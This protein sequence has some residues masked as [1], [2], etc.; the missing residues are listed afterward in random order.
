MRRFMNRPEKP[1]LRI[2]HIG[3]F[4]PRLRWRW[5]HV[6]GQ[7]AVTGLAVQE[8]LHRWELQNALVECFQLARNDFRKGSVRIAVQLAEQVDFTEGR[9]RLSELVTLEERLVL[10]EVRKDLGLLLRKLG[11]V[12]LLKGEHR[13]SN[14]HD[15][16]VQVGIH[17]S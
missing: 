2:H 6:H 13:G 3:D 14:L 17:A 5:H 16:L 7:L 1:R 9:A 4:W 15:L 12:E 11:S 10:G 8:L